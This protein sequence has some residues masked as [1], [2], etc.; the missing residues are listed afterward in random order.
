MG[1]VLTPILSFLK[2]IPIWVYIIVVCLGWGGYQRYRANSTAAEYQQAQAKAA[3]EREKALALTIEETAR[4][5]SAQQEATN[6]AEKKSV[7]AVGDAAA[8][9]TAAARL[10]DKLASID[11][12]G[13]F[14]S[15]PAPSA[16]QASR[17]ADIL[18]RCADEY[19]KVAGIADRAI[20]AGLACEA[21]YKALGK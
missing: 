3:S 14:A 12:S 10:R 16:S 20:I 15:A 21:N 17:V 18:N 6:E 7:K 13:G 19:T 1:L 5:L 4:R 2:L 9:R 11:A 8:A